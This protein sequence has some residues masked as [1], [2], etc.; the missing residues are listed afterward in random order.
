MSRVQTVSVTADAVDGGIRED[1]AREWL[2]AA[3]TWLRVRRGV[4]LVGDAREPGPG[5]NYYQARV[6]QADGQTVRLLLNAVAKLV[7]ASSDDGVPVLGPLS[8]IDLAE[9]E[10]FIQAGFAVASESDLTRS[11]TTQ[12]LELLSAAQLADMR[13]HGAHTVGDLLFNW[14]D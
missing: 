12:E 5:W 2:A 7:A 6:Q 1:E 3:H 10:P 14:F 8:F 13:Y 4:S 11:L 9:P